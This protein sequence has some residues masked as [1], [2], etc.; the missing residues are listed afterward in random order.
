MQRPQA[1]QAPQAP[2]PPH[3]PQAP[4]APQAPPSPQRRLYESTMLACLSF[5]AGCTDV[6]SF[7][8]IGNVFTSAMTGNTALLAIAIGNGQWRAASR[9]SAALLGFTLGVALG[10]F[11]S[12]RVH[13]RQQLLLLEL[14]IVAACAA[15]WSEVDL[16]PGLPLYGV[17]LLSALSMGVQAVAAQTVSSSGVSTVVFTTPLVHLVMAATRAL[18]RLPGGPQPSAATGDRVYSFAAYAGG[19]LLAAVGLSHSHVAV[20]WA[21]PL[22]VLLALVSSPKGRP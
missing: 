2:H 20:A 3:P 9:S 7:L 6:L 12:S 15:L 22:A 21:P 17:V 1:P 13:A 18:A 19:A 11:V 10:T 8:K 5:A 14:V 16:T 4:Q